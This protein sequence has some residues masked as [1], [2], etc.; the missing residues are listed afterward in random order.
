MQRKIG[1][2]CFLVGAISTKVELDNS[3]GDSQLLSRSPHY[4]S[5]S[6]FVGSS[7]NHLVGSSRLAERKRPVTFSE[8]SVAS[9]VK[10]WAKPR[11]NF[12]ISATSRSSNAR[13][14]SPNRTFPC[15][16]VS[17]PASFTLAAVFN[18][19]SGSKSCKS[20]SVSPV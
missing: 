8:D 9:Q 17:A 7:L 15:F 14:P 10:I 13:P 2:T 18:W 1:L 5:S 20:G 16:S 11:P 4:F 3:P 6:P 12:R 19:S